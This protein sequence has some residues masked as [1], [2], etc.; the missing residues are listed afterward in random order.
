MFYRVLAILFSSQELK[1]SKWRWNDEL[2]L[3]ETNEHTDDKCIS[4]YQIEIYNT[5]FRRFTGSRAAIKIRRRNRRIR[6]KPKQIQGSNLQNY[7]SNREKLEESDGVAV[8]RNVGVWFPAIM[9]T[10]WGCRSSGVLVGEWIF[11]F[12]CSSSEEEECFW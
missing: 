12:W 1:W 4:V 5:N 8:A 10:I 2:K 6:S 7:S 9:T 3:I 11:V